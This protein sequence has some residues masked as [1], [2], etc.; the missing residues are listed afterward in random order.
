MDNRYSCHNRCRHSL[1]VHIVLVTKYRRQML[2]GSA[3]D[4]VKQKIND[5]NIQIPYLSNT[6][7]GKSF[8]LMDILLAV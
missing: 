2:K 3:A 8:G 6:G 7:K 4:D 5:V 1:K